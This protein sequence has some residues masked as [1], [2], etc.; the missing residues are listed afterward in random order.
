MPRNLDAYEDKAKKKLAV[1]IQRCLTDMLSDVG[2]SAHHRL[3]NR[4]AKNRVQNKTFVHDPDDIFDFDE[5]DE[6][7]SSDSESA[8]DWDDE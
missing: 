4:L 3:S 8:R 1:S 7:P 5:M 6:H 2:D